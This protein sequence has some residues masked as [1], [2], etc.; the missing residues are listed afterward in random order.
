MTWW[1]PPTTFQPKHCGGLQ[2]KITNHLGYLHMGF[3]VVWISPVA[4]NL[5]DASSSGQDKSNHRCVRYSSSVSI[6]R[7]GFIMR[8]RCRPKGYDHLNFHLCTADG[9]N[10][11]NSTLPKFSGS[12]MLGIVV[13]DIA[14][15]GSDLTCYGFSRLN[16]FSDLSLIHKR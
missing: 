11:L 12:P 16:L 7:V 10:T 8:S 6:K 9:S 2:R 1:L 3:D 14:A 15:T 13:N 4:P 5:E